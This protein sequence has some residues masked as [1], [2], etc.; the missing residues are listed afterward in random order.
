[1][2]AHQVAQDRPTAR[3]RLSA[4]DVM[5]GREVADLLRMPVSTVEDL[6]RRGE[7]PSVKVGRR[8]LYIRTQI[9]GLLTGGQR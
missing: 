8:R 5:L 6:A 4:R 3:P 2:T 7:L 1:M 9:E